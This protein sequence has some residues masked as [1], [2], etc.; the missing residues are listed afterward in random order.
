[1]RLVTWNVNSIRARLVRVLA[2]LER[3]TPDVVCLQELKTTEEAFPWREIEAAG[4]R[5]TVCG[6][7]TYNGVAI[8]TRVEHQYPRVGFD[9]GVAAPEA[10]MVGVTVQN[11]RIVCVYVPNGGRIG[12]P[13]W[14]HKLRWLERL[15]AYLEQACDAQ[16]PL[17]V[18]GDYNVAPDDGDVAIPQAWATSV[19]CHPAARE[20]L[21]RLLDW[22]LVDVF[23]SKYPE[24]G[25]YSWWD[26]R[27]QA[28]ARNDGLRIDLVLT[29]EWVAEACM[30]A[31]IDRDERRGR[32]ASDHAPV[33]VELDLE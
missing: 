18:C 24:G 19:L 6:Q 20:R 12:S 25:E 8:L 29:S 32:D 26:Y 22:G 7:K 14:K 4:Y 13:K 2:W 33:V 3:H 30:G 11:V 15:A 21:Q 16:E 10:R 17:V 1:M 9:D 5:A 23:R 28:L 31:W 27:N